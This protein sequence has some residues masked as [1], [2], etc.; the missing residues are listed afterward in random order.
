LIRFPSGRST[1]YYSWP[2]LEASGTLALHDG[3]A[4]RVSGMAWLD[5]QWGSFDAFRDLGRYDW[6]A[7]QLDDGSSVIL[8]DAAHPGG[9]T[10]LGRIMRPDGRQQAVEFTSEPLG[11]WT[12]PVTK[13]TYP[14]GWR[15]A[16]KGVG[17]EM[18]V[19]PVL[20]DQ[21]VSHLVSHPFW[22]G[23]CT[24]SGTAAGKRISGRAYVEL[25]GYD[26]AAR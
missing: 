6:F 10:R 24:V 17:M 20:R 5:H 12:S 14:S 9:R 3:E 11:R 16:L 15:L 8:L 13:A 2:R 4:T 22:E 26:Q 18:K 25:V 19:A 21:E 23:A 1:Y 7:L